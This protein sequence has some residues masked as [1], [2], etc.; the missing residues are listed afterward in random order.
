MAGVGAGVSSSSKRAQSTDHVFAGHLVATEGSGILNW[1]IEGAMMYRREMES[2]GRLTLTE[3][4]RKR[5]ECL[6]ADS[7]NVAEFVAGHL[8][9]KDGLD[10]TTDELLLGYHRICQE[11]NWKPVAAHTFQTR[12]PDL[13]AG[14]LNVT[15]RNDIK[16]DGRTVRGF[17]HVT[18]V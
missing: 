11:K 3:D 17:K 6:L 13:L 14:H 12:L 15:R 18:L 2:K 5:I 1:L 9:K 8:Q 10:V 4:Q 7:D 16:R